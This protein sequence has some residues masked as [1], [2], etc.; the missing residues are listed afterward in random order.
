MP[1]NIDPEIATIWPPLTDA[2]FADLVADIKANGCLS[3]LV[4]WEGT[5]L[6]GHHRHKICTDNGVGFRVHNIE[7]EDRAAAMRWVLH[8]QSGRRNTTASQR[9]FAAAK[10]ADFLAAEGKVRRTE[11]LQKGRDSS[12]GAQNAPTGKPARAADVAAKGAGVSPRLV[13]EAQKVLHKGTIDLQSQVQSGKKSV[14]QAVKEIDTKPKPDPIAGPVDQL[15]NPL[16]AKQ[17]IQQ[18]FAR[19][20][21]VKGLQRE[22]STLKGKLIEAAA[23][24]KDP[25][26]ARFDV[27]AA[28]ADMEHVFQLLKAIAPHAVCPYCAGGERGG[29]DN[30]A[31]CK[32]LGWL[33]Y[34]LYQAV[35]RELK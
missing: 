34:Y 18:A 2:E 20:G 8:H 21:E 9:S 19:L 23:R 35:P 33:D 24:S 1:I 5:L 11:K 26:F 3:P 13:T 16:P 12:V 4:V 7:M 27:S 29:A 31:A 25:I 30:C 28:K 22:V 15:G 32:G 14:G 17:S 10:V 6:D